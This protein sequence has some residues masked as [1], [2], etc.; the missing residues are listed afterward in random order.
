MPGSVVG[1]NTIIEDYATVGMNATIMPKVKIGKGSFIGAGAVV[2]KNVKENEIVIGNPA[3]FLKKI[4]H[5][6]DLKIL[7]TFLMKIYLA[8]FYSSDLKRSATRFKHQAEAMRIYDKI[9]IYNQDDLNQDFKDY[10]SMLL[11]KG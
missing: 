10:I 2:T 5:T 8:T 4:K 3:K 7:E 1:G 6:V 9:L 11:K